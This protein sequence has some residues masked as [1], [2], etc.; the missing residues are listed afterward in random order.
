[1]RCATGHCTCCGIVLLWPG[2]DHRQPLLRVRDLADDTMTMTPMVWTCMN[3]TFLMAHKCRAMAMF[4]WEQTRAERDVKA[5]CARILSC[6]GRLFLFSGVHCPFIMTAQALVG[7]YAG[8]LPCDPLHW[9]Y[10]ALSKAL[11]W[12]YMSDSIEGFSDNCG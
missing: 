3:F 7:R 2:R 6:E 8:F 9:G 5:L 10:R 4:S 1:M 11:N 12:P